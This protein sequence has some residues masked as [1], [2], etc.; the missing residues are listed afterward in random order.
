MSETSLEEKL[1]LVP[2]D[3]GVYLFKDQ[4]GKVIYV[5]KAKVLR[6]RVRSYYQRIEE[7]EPKTR[8]LVSH[9][10]DLD[11]IVV[12]TEKEA[13][14]LE[15]TLIKKYI[16]RY[17]IRLRDDKRYMS[18]KL[19]MSHSFPRL[20]VVRKVQADGSLY[21]GPFD[22]ARAVRETLRFLGSTF[23]LR[24]C[25]DRQ[26]AQRTRPCLQFQIG[27]SLAPCVG[28][29]DRE[30]YFVVVNQ[31]RAFFAGR[32]AEIIPELTAQMEA[33]AAAMNFEE[34]ARIRDRIEAINQTLAKQKAV[35]PMTG[36]RDVY[37]LYR[38][39]SALVVCLMFIRNGAITGQRILPFKD[40]EEEDAVILSQLIGQIYSASPVVPDEI[41]LPLEPEGGIELLTGWIGELAGRR[42][43]VRV[44]QRGDARRLVEMAEK[45][46][47]RH[48]AARKSQLISVD[49]VLEDIRQKLLLP[50]RP[51]TIECFDIS[52]VS[53]K[54]AV[55]SLVR[56]HMGEPEK[57]GYRRFR[58]KIS[59]ESDDYAMM[60]E[61][62]TR[63]VMRGLTEGNL[64]DLMLVDGGK[65]HLNVAL[66]VLNELGRPEQPTAAIAKI[67][68]LGPDDR[69]PEDKIYLPG[70]KNPV[71]FRAASHALLLLQRIRDEAHRFA[72]TYHRALRSKRIIASVLDDIPNLGPHKK[73]ALLRAF[74]SLKRI[75]EAS[76]ED[77]G[78]A[79]G[80]GPHLAR[81]IYEHLHTA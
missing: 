41:L 25:S 27:R 1:R 36:D 66:E 21:Y 64:P 61:V 51:E 16:P 13:L 78:T 72:L 33:Q 35:T 34:A 31:V 8:L 42:I 59:G 32:M 70:R 52:D 53:G 81:A 69:G 9:I 20:Y 30:Q 44:P 79:P 6:N 54:F 67:K 60:R 73:K 57:S 5:G 3:P 80:I 23:P 43:E 29:V 46:A 22:S 76:L 24:K 58:I 45:N 15:A 49:D 77:L 50:R 28:Y 55:A 19:D 39:G 68:G 74:G 7:H 47:A 4:D 62:L 14:I 75:R 38:E 26:F 18:L 40:M 17:N 11:W 2:P 63:R 12:D 48:F 56:F 71:V 10:K 37:G 65:G